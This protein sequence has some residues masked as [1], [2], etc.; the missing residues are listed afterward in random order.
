[1]RVTMRLSKWFERRPRLRA[2]H[3]PF[4]IGERERDE[5][6]WCMDRAPD[7]HEIPELIR[8]RTTTPCAVNDN[9]SGS[10]DLGAASMRTIRY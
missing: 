2:R 8:M 10:L 5:W 4:P 6:L 3:L 1:M 9:R 7:E